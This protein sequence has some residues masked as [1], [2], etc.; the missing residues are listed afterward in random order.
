MRKKLRLTV[1]SIFAITAIYAQPNFTSGDMPGAGDGDTLMYLNGTLLT[2]NL[3]TET[4]S[5]YTWNFSALP[6]STYPNFKIVDSF[7]LKTHNVSAPYV[8]ATLEE[9]VQDGTAGDVNLFSYSG[10]TLFIHRVGGV[11]SGAATYNPPL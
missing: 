11:A 9:Y 4:G 3:D 5:G 10:D 6:F 7:R 2:N 8:N 1:L